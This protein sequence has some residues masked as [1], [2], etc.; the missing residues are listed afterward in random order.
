MPSLAVMSHV[1]PFTAKA[2]MPSG[3]YI[4]FTGHGRM[5]IFLSLSDA[6]K[7]FPARLWSLKPRPTSRTILFDSRSAT[8]IA[9]FSWQA[10][11][12]VFESGETAMY[13]G[14]RSWAT[15]AFFP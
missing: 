12:A 7:P 5:R 10:T 8:A 13:S 15:L 11:H 14:S 9:L 4:P 6:S 3:W 2:A 1:L